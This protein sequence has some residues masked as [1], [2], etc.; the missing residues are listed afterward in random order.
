MCKRWDELVWPLPL[1][2]PP[3][4]K[5]NEPHCFIQR[6]TVELGPTMPPVQFWV[7]S[8]IS[9]FICFTQRLI[10]EG[11]VLT[12]DPVSNGAEWI[13]V[14]GITQDLSRAEMSALTLY[15]MVLHSPDTESERLNRF[16][17]SRDT[18]TVGGKGGGRHHSDD[19]EDEDAPHSQDTEE[20]AHK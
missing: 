12:Y 18:G 14:R 11:A 3:T 16:G 6:Q 1:S 20:G 9:K 8:P 7:S 13:P 19:N 15:N 2:S 4:P 17:E 10:F 5:W